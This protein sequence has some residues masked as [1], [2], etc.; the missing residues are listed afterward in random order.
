MFGTQDGWVTADGRQAEPPQHSVDIETDPGLP[1]RLSY[2]RDRNEP[3]TVA[4]VAR[5]AAV[6]II[7]LGLRAELG[8]QVERVR[9]SRTRLATAHFEERRRIERDLHDGAQQRLL[10]IALQ[11][12]SARVNGTAGVLHEGIDRAVAELA[13]TVQELR[14]LASGLQPAAL[15]GG[16][17]C[18]ATAELSHRIP[19]R[20]DVHVTDARFPET[21]ESAAWFVIAEGVANAV[22]HAQAQTVSITVV[23]ASGALRVL[24]TDDGVGGADP[25]G[26]GLQGLADRVSALGGHLV[27]G[28]GAAG[29]TRIEAVFPCVS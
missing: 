5:S 13:A 14:S 4:A 16:G 27:V 3:G 8:R 17:L 23:S 26:S 21:I 20:L 7:N 29:G 11:L 12:Q 6:Q 15:A 18:A 22:K 10:A 19:M 9:E 24:V 2:D 28:R 25:R 1:A